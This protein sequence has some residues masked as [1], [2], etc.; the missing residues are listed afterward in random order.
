M[1]P[2]K[3]F[4]QVPN[5]SSEIYFKNPIVNYKS[6]SKYLCMY[7]FIARKPCHETLRPAQFMPV[8]SCP[9][10][11]AQSGILD[12]PFESFLQRNVT[13][14]SGLFTRTVFT[15]YEPLQFPSLRHF[16]QFLPTQRDVFDQYTRSKDSFTLAP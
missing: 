13:F 12:V 3:K 14:N 2:L 9:I 7:I 6:L 11:P 4:S 1:V 10:A 15:D 8:V 16:T 5:E